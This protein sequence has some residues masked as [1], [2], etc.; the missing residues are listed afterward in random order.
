[1]VR[2]RAAVCPSSQLPTVLLL[3]RRPRG[4]DGRCGCVRCVRDLGV[5]SAWQL[6]ASLGVMEEASPAR[7]PQEE[8]NRRYVEEG[9]SQE[10]RQTQIIG[11][12][13]IWLHNRED[14]AAAMKVPEEGAEDYCSLLDK[15]VICVNSGASF[16]VRCAPWCDTWCGASSGMRYVFFCVR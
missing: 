16:L 1:M 12:V 8:N 9:V 5:E 13:R 11:L 6:L 4:H 2:R 7:S 3:P 14:C 15:E 10:D